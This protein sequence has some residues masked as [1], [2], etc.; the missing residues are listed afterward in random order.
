MLIAHKS[1]ITS[2]KVCFVFIVFFS[3]IGFVSVRK[4]AG[5]PAVSAA[6]IR[7]RKQKRERGE[8]KGPVVRFRVIDEYM[9][10]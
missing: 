7:K 10:N 1:N 5:L 4:S 2:S 6:K 9:K 8:K 3:T